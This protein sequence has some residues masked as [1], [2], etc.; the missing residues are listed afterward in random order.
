MAPLLG[1]HLLEERLH[2]IA[3]RTCARLDAE[4]LCAPA[5]DRLSDCLR[6]RSVGLSHEGRNSKLSVA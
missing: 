4:R 6:A 3:R 2:L 5:Y 1:F